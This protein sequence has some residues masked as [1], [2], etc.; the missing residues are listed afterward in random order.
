MSIRW[1]I[2]WICSLAAL[3]PSSASA[4][5]CNFLPDAEVIN[6]SKEVFRG[7]VLSLER[8]GTFDFKYPKSMWI[9]RLE[10]ITAWKGSGDPELVVI[11]SMDGTACGVPFKKGV[12]YLVFAAP[13][14]AVAPLWTSWCQYTEEFRPESSHMK[15]IEEHLPKLI[16]KPKSSAASSCAATGAGPSW[17]AL[18]LLAAALIR[19]QRLALFLRCPRCASRCGRC[20]RWRRGR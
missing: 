18:W 13:R 2:L 4:C 7:R 16:L 1:L 5:S 19:R 8:P 10:V 3:L 15:Y 12:E 17:A 20:M 11:T 6:W 14:S 9:V